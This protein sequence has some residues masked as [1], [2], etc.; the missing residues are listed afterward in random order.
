ME[1]DTEQL[2]PGLKRER[3][4]LDQ[5]GTMEDV[6]I[7]YNAFLESHDVVNVKVNGREKSSSAFLVQYREKDSV[8]VP[9][10]RKYNLEEV[11]R[12]IKATA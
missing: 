1:R 9:M 10:R 11:A 8:S 3:I 4:S 7:A 2:R 6:R 5:Y 12:K